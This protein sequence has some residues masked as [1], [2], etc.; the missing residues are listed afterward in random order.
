MTKRMVGFLTTTALSIAVMGGAVSAADLPAKAPIY[1]APPAVIYNWTGFYVAGGFGYGMFNL[2][3]SLTN[4][5]VL[6]S[7]NVTNAGRGLFGTVGLGFDYQF[8]DRIVGGV[9]ADFDFSNIKGHFSDPWWERSGEIKQTWAWAA[10]A[11]VGYLVNPAVLSYFGAGFTRARFSSVALTDSG[12]GTSG[13]DITEAQTYNG[14][15]LSSGVEAMLPGLP[16][17]SVKTEY[18]FADY[19]KKDVPIIELGPRFIG[20]GV[21]NI[22]PYVQTVRA[23]LAYKFGWGRE[24]FGSGAMAYA[25][26]PAPVAYNWTGFYIGAGGGY[27]MFNLDS[28]LSQNGVLQSDNQ[29]LGGRGWFGTAGGGFDYQFNGPFVAGLFADFDFSDIH[30]NWHDP[31]SSAG[32]PIKQKWAWFAGARAG[33]LITPDVL[34]YLSGGF[35]RSRFSDVH[36]FNNGI[37]SQ[38]E[39]D[40]MPATTYN[41]WFVGG[42]AE[43]MIPWFR[44]LSLKSEYRFADYGSKDVP[45]LNSPSTGGSVNVHPFVQ[46]IRT[47]LVYRFGV[48]R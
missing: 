46:T 47:A 34:A 2:D 8:S 26:A 37:S 41:G 17:W 36:F 29:T 14:W 7:D 22:H 30:G 10:G 40:F 42:G 21:V 48:S 44:G 31:N 4:N 38:P 13:L 24:A 45:I 32:G 27:G 35:T 16:G 25:A 23:E 28:S 9:F 5:G 12:L 15:F 18:R 6:V 20:P 1:K 3:S 19:G 33:Y 11:R 43:A 39:P